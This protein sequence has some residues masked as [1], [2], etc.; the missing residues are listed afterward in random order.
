VRIAE[1]RA[2]SKKVEQKK[3]REERAEMYQSEGI[4]IPTFLIVTQKIKETTK[5]EIS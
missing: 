2:S 4:T 3:N 5:V 1:G